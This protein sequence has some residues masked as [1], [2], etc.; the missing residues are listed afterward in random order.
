MLAA[1]AARCRRSTPVIGEVR[2]GHGLFAV[3]ELVR[4]RATRAPLAPWPQ[5][6][7][8]CSRRC[9]PMRC[10]AGVSF[11][12]RGNLIILAPPLVIEERDLADALAAA[13][14]AAGGARLVMS[15]K[16]TYSTMFNPPRGDARALRGGARR[17]V[18]AQ[19]GARHLLFIDGSDVAGAASYPQDQPRSMAARSGQLR[20]R[21]SPPRWPP[22]SRP[23]S[24]PS[25][26]GA[27]TPLAERVRLSKRVAALIEERVY[28]IAAAL[29]L[30]VGKNRMEALGEAQETRRLLHRLCRRVR[31]QRRL[32]SRAGRRPAAPTSRRATAAC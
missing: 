7:R 23:P 26:P 15:F 22:R 6:H 16:L 10:A 24:A 31:A 27:R 20:R 9:L 4:D 25:R 29:C 12:T 28:E 3:I 30:E 21:R 19:L 18:R 8:R 2:G 32:R 17:S 14:S 11:A 1:L 5:T 13:R